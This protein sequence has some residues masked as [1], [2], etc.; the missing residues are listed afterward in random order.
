MLK[1]PA[2]RMERREVALEVVVPAEVEAGWDETAREAER[3][4]RET[5]GYALRLIRQGAYVEA[6]F[7]SPA[8][9]ERYRDVLDELGG[10]IGWA[11]RV[12]ESANQ[13]EIVREARRLTPDGCRVR[14][15]PKL[16]LPERN[17]VVPV[18]ETPA[19]EEQPR[20]KEAFRERTGLDLAWE[21]IKV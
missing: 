18:V 7:V 5:T 1:A 19:E 8:V 6:A 11:I 12:R 15:A 2:L 3:I 9:G 16:F 20:L 13:E 4:F 14:G 17:V 21:E 10:R